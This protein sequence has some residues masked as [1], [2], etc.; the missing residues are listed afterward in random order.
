MNNIMNIG[1]LTIAPINRD[2]RSPAHRDYSEQCKITKTG[3]IPWRWDDS[4][5]N[6]AK[7]GEPFAFYFHKNKLIFHTITDI[8][9]PEDRLDSWETKNRNVLILST[10]LL[11][12]TWLEWEALGGPESQMG[13]YKPRNLKQKYS[14]VHSRLLSL[15][16]EDLMDPIEL[17]ELPEFIE[18]LEPID[19]PA[20]PA[21]LEPPSAKLMRDFL[22]TI[23]TTEDTL[24][25]VVYQSK[26]IHAGFSNNLDN[27]LLNMGSYHNN[28]P[29]YPRR[30][31]ADYRKISTDYNQ[32]E[33][34]IRQKFELDL[35]TREITY[36]HSRRRKYKKSVFLHLCTFKTPIFLKVFYFIS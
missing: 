10:P 25:Y 7:I 4:C 5:K 1:E 32:W 17:I 23:D 9:S 20:L 15:Y 35:D 31:L 3:E 24:Y 36:N 14:L 33:E 13:T 22:G 28:V 30:I 6:R 26:K 2:E 34:F 11:E 16:Q 12:I 29:N 27:L 18:E 8:K 19:L 21:L